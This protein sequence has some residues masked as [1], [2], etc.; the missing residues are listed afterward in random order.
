MR[1]HRRPEIRLHDGGCCPNRT[2]MPVRRFEIGEYHVGVD[3]WEP[4]PSHNRRTSKRSLSLD[5]SPSRRSRERRSSVAE[6]G[7]RIHAF[8][9]V[10]ALVRFVRFVGVFVVALLGA[11]RLVH[12][13]PAFR[14]RFRE[15]ELLPAFLPLGNRRIDI[16]A[17]EP[18]FLPRLRI[19]YQAGAPCV[20]DR[21]DHLRLVQN[22]VFS[23][24]ELRIEQR[25]DVLRRIDFA[26]NIETNFIHRVGSK[27]QSL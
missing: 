13:A 17:D 24:P 26:G 7:T 2:W 19:G 25:V 14:R 10:V 22:L 8:A 23:Q 3:S 15:T 20:H 1:H 12:S 27:N 5:R 11:R 18:E 6:D 4:R 16:H 21:L 9:I